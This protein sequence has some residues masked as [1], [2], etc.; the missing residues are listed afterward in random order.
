MLKADLHIHTEYSFD[1][2]TSLES[3]I[4]RC[5]KSG[6]NCVAIADHGTIE[7]A[8]ELKKTA[9]FEV[10]IAE[11]ILTPLG[12]IMGLFLTE[13][14]PSG[15]PAKEAITRIR[16]QNGL[17]CLPHPFDRFRGIKRAN[18]N[19]HQVLKELAPD[20][21]IVEVFNSRAFP[22]GNPDKKARLFAEAHGLLCSAGS[23]A[24]TSREIGHAYVELPE[25]K[26]VEEFR[27]SLAQGHVFGHH[28]C[29][30]VHIPTTLEALKRRL[31]K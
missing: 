14:I 28:A 2:A 27:T 24:H 25:F 19:G 3:I 16:A 4:Q 10:I 13:Q 7:G 15:I 1:S 31:S 20:I 9:P 18:H 22:L 11:E 12:E 23:D 17:V 29:L 5:L 21:D 8:L 30:T 26:S 6:I